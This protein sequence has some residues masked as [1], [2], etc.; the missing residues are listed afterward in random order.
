MNFFKPKQE[1]VEKQTQAEEDVIVKKEAEQDIKEG[2]RELAQMYLEGEEIELSDEKQLVVKNCM[3][4]R[5]DKL[6]EDPAILEGFLKKLKT[7]QGEAIDKRTVLDLIDQADKEVF[8]SSLADSVDGLSEE[9]KNYIHEA[10]MEN[11]S[12]IN[13]NEKAKDVFI[14]EIANYARENTEVSAV[15]AKQEVEKIIKNI[16][17]QFGEAA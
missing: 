10:A 5:W 12:I 1:E 11:I 4:E 7:Q 2:Q 16:L 3:L 14:N 6:S 15:D 8:E 13:S 9:T 17:S